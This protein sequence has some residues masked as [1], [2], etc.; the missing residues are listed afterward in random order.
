MFSFKIPR[1]S[2]FMN[3]LLFLPRL[4]NCGNNLSTHF[5]PAA[6]K[7]THELQN[8]GSCLGGVEDTQVSSPC[9]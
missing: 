3:N 8:N 7:G 5:N 9:N 4:V 1:Q 6:S 2:C